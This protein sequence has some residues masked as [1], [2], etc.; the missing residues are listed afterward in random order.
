MPPIV[1]DGKTSNQKALIQDLKS[2]VKGDFSLK[3]TNYTTILFVENKDDHTN[4]VKNMKDEKMSYHTYTH[5]D[6]K[7]HAF[8][9][10]GL[11]EGTKINDIEEELEEEHEIKP[12][13]VYQMKTKERP[14][15]LVVTDPAI[16]L[17]YLNRNTR[18]ILHT[19]VTW[20]LHITTTSSEDH[21]DF[22]LCSSE[23]IFLI[24]FGSV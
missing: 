17:E 9:L 3:H 21:H 19:R 23:S 16:T 1:I 12:R 10:R 7:S 5:R 24:T 15:F 8:V 2:I 4:V 14:L 6:D 11:A 20:E 22:I 13:A 18:R